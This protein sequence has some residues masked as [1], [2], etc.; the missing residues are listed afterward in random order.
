MAGS[1]MASMSASTIILTSWWKPTRGAH[2][3]TRLALRASARRS[4]TSVGRKYRESISTCSCQSSPAYANASSTN[5][6]TECDSPV[7]IT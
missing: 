7:P 3:S 5:S 2:S 1:P 6:R 4:L